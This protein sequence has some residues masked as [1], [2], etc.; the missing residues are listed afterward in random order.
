M[1]RPDRGGVL[2]LLGL[3]L[4][5]YLAEKGWHRHLMYLTAMGLLIA[6]M[7]G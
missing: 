1:R 6:A 3:L 7:W 5:W 4:G 2:L